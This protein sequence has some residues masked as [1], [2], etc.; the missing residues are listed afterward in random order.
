MISKFVIQNFSG[1]IC[2]HHKHGGWVRPKAEMVLAHDW[3]PLVY[4]IKTNACKDEIFMAC[5]EN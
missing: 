5:Q 4:F 2:W 3:C 1:L